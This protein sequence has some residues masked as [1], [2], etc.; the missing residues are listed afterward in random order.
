VLVEALFRE[1]Q[2]STGSHLYL[3]GSAHLFVDPAAI[4]INRK[5]LLGKRVA[6]HRNGTENKYLLD[7]GISSA[8]TLKIFGISNFSLGEVLDS[9]ITFDSEL[10]RKFGSS[11]CVES[12]NLDITG[13]SII[14]T[15]QLMILTINHTL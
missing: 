12:S 11:G 10:V 15:N 8:P 6:E 5:V 13:S 14:K 2:H 4:K 1:G 7:N 9:G 3:A